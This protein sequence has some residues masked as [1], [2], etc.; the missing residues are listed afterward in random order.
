MFMIGGLGFVTSAV[1]LGVRRVGLLR[2][3][4]RV[5]G[6]V[7][8]LRQHVDMDTDA[9]RETPVVRYASPSGAHE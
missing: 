6:R 8:R 7:V 1:R 4:V 2:R 5:T 9:I 3:G